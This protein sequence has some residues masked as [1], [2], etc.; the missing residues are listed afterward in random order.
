MIR[1]LDGVQRHQLGRG[2]RQA[3]EV[4]H[5]LFARFPGQVDQFRTD[6]ARKTQ[7]AGLGVSH[8]QAQVG[9]FGLQAMEL[10]RQE[11]A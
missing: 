6:L 9:K 2:A 11:G 10:L 3:P 4:R 5:R 1:L 7:L 8:L